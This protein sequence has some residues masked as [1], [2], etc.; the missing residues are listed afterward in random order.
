M[1]HKHSQNGF[2]LL[3]L[4]IS[5]T[6]GLLLIGGAVAMMKG[7]STALLRNEINADMVSAI[8]LANNTIRHDIQ[9]AGYFGR[10]RFP[11][12]IT[13]RTDDLN[14]LPNIAGDCSGGFYADIR[15]YV[16]AS[17]DDNPFA[18]TCLSNVNYAAG[19]DV[20]VVRH[21]IDGKLGGTAVGALDA[22]TL[23]L[24]SNPAGGELF[25]GNSPPPIDP[26]PY[27]GQFS[28]DIGKRFYQAVTSVYFVGNPPASNGGMGAGLYRL[29]LSPSASGPFST[30][31]LISTEIGNLQVMF[32]IEDCSTTA[33]VGPNV[34]DGDIDQYVDGSGLDLTGS[35]PSYNA[36]RRIR[37]V[38]A[39]F[40][41]LS[42]R[43]KGADQ[44]GTKTHS[45]RG[46][47][48]S[49]WLPATFQATT[50]HVRNS[51]EIFQ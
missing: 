32:G 48:V 19:T 35:L 50:Y 16:Y 3:E 37:T 33:L 4:M 7:S 8:R 44:M 6:I 30:P 15:R 13:G 24:Y 22:N 1:T 11:T 51:E 28:A 46:V 26:F 9:S 18:T 2:T 12:E 34:C 42:G 41:S 21:A 40:T 17:N 29:S 10:T 23:Y 27:A 36:V 20:L 39:A 25:M 47:D 14:P 38:S 45:L 31:Q 43:I 5:L 49:A